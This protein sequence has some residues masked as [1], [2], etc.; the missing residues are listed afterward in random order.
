MTIVDDLRLTV[1]LR[2]EQRAQGEPPGKGILAQQLCQGCDD[3]A[4]VLDE[5]LVVVVYPQEAA[6]A[7]G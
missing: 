3:H 6:H 1:C 7:L 4:K 2:V 5:L